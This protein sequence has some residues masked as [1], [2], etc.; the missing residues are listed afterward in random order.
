MLDPRAVRRFRSHRGALVGLGLVVGLV[1]FAVLGPW[2]TSHDPNLSDFATGRD[3]AGR[4]IGPSAA[5]WLGVDHLMRD[6]LAR[7]AH[8][9]RISLTVG[10]VATTMALSLGALVGIVSGWFEGTRLAAVDLLLMR[11]TD[12]GLAFPYLLLVTAVGAAL[13]RTS[14]LTILVVLGATSWFGTAR[15]VRSKTLEIR[16]LDFI[17]AA[18]ALGASTAWVLARHVLPN[19]AGPLVVIGTV[20]VAQMILAES[21]LSYL[22]VGLPPPN[23][24]W[25]RMLQEG[26]TFY[27]VAPRLVLAPGLAI[28]CAVLGF[29]LLGEGLR[30]ALD[31]REAP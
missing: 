27:V 23:A 21:V 28:L 7:L 25:G 14:V 20:S 4:P 17:Q 31:P 9:A 3:A 10:L 30:D 15:L 11:L 1:T 2:L 22:Q 24:T 18:R 13:Q 19:V 6:E 5:H 16:A 29:N 12:V 26:Q 8:G